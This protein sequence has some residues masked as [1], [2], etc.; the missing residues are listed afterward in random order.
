NNVF[1]QV[2]S[3]T[4]KTGCHVALIGHT[5]K[6][7][8]RGSRGSNAFGGHVDLEVILSGDI[9]KTA[10]VNKANDVPEGPLFSFK[11][12]IHD[13]G[14]DEDGDPITVNIVSADD[15]EP[16]ASKGREPKLSANQQTFS[17]LLHDAGKDGLT[18]ENGNNQAKAIE[19]GTSRKATLHD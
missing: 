9:V 14:T 7:Q 8:S 18:L 17:R 11:S 2:E 10:T 1:V 5:G 6:D 3:V 13:F 19:I 16:V 15:V 4:K 12:E